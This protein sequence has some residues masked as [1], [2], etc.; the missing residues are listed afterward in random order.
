MEKEDR[1][2]RRSEVGR[3][4]DGQVSGKMKK[5]GLTCSPYAMIGQPIE[6]HEEDKNTLHTML[7]VV[8]AFLSCTSI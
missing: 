5:R 2:R 6:K 8:P 7:Q 1:G 3:H 4:D